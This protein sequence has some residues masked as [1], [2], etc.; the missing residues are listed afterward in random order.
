LA[1]LAA[2]SSGNRLELVTPLL[3]SLALAAPVVIFLA[4]ML[5]LQTYV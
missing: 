4:Y 1:C 5:R 3:I 2:A